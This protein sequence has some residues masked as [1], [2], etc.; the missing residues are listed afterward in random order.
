MTDSVCQYGHSRHNHSYPCAAPLAD[1]EVLLGSIP[2]F[3]KDI[4]KAT[5][6]GWD[7][8]GGV[9]RY[10]LGPIGV[11]CV[12]DYTLATEVLTDTA[13][14]GKLGKTSPVRLLVGEGLLSIADHDRWKR[15]RRMMQPM[16][17]R[18][19]IAG[20]CD[21]MTAAAAEALGDLSVAGR[22]A[23]AVD[24]HPIMTRTTLDVVSRCMF[25]LKA[26]D[27]ELAVTPDAV[28][29]VMTYAFNRQQNP[30]SP[31][32][33]WPSATNRR[34]RELMRAFDDFIHGLV[35][36][37]RENPGDRGDLLDMLLAAKDADTG[38]SLS[39][40]EIR[41]EVI[42]TFAAGHESTAQTLT[43][44][45]YLLSLNHGVRAE[46]EAELDRVLAGRLPTYADLPEL[47]YTLQVVSEALRIYPSAPIIPRLVLRD[48]VLGPY[49]IPKGARLLINVVNIGHDGKRWADP[50][51]FDPHRFEGDK[52]REAPHR[53]YLPFGAGPRICIGK[54]FALMEAQL[55]LAVIAQ[56]FRFEHDPTHPVEAEAKFTL[57]PRYGMRMIVSER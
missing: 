35:R 22:A 39:D 34:F 30:F 29:E 9:V 49:R 47:A 36:D 7:L 32:V 14:Y 27:A 44:I 45:F 51:T 5:K 43:W 41:D 42:T 6:R 11:Y 54:H 48:T 46:L 1:R 55:I 4:L 26:A 20:M 8:H 17:A 31:P 3:R 10:R 56:R 38:E 52:P 21:T 13:V 25:G 28:D 2:A 57:R 18:S 37:R 19:H 33:W 12:S 15:N 24:I 23:G 53:A 40:A 16:Y 50:D